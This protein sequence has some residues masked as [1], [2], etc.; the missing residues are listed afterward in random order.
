MGKKTKRTKM[1]VPHAWDALTKEE[2][3]KLIDTEATT[4]TALERAQQAGIVFIDEIDKIATC[5]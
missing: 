5:A 4:R 2:T 3:E 1:K